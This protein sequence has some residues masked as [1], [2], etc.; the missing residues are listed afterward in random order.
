M[1]QGFLPSIAAARP[2][3]YR[4]ASQ[5]RLKVK[6]RVKNNLLIFIHNKNNILTHNFIDPLSARFQGVT[7]NSNPFLFCTAAKPACGPSHKALTPFLI[8]SRVAS[9]KPAAHFHP[10]KKRPRK[11]EFP[12]P[13]YLFAAQRRCSGISL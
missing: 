5:L 4:P 9:S 10:L 12:E 1:H 7:G 13:T 6:N 3:H 2:E 11:N 8:V